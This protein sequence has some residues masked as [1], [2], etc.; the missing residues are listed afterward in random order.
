MNIPSP[1]SHAYLLSGGSAESRHAFGQRMA[2]AYLCEGEHA[3]CGVCRACRKVKGSIH[4]DLVTVAPLEGKREISVDQ[5]RS[6]RS[7]AYIRPNEGKRKVYVIEPAEKLNPSAQNAL[8]KV[9]EEGPEYAAFLLITG[10]P[11]IML[12]TIRSRCESLAIP[13]EAEEIDPELLQKAEKLA[14]LLLTGSELAVAEGMAELEQEKPK[15]DAL[16]ELLGHTAG[17]VSRH[18]GENPRRAA[19]ILTAIKQCL[20]NSAYNPNPG[21]TLGWLAAELFR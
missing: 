13:P 21:H 8:L 14:N 2:A 7:D 9:L 11:G 5:I 18:L 19:Q 10:E 15:S 4:P 1:L 16:M 3:P 17:C 6:L 12:E 20:G